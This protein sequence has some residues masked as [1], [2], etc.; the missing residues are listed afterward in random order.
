MYGVCIIHY[1]VPLLQALGLEWSSRPCQTT[2]HGHGYAIQNKI[3]IAPM[4]IAVIDAHS[5]HIAIHSALAP[6]WRMD[7]DHPLDNAV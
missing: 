6:S 2:G 4:K 7:S 1:Q 5:A 3:K